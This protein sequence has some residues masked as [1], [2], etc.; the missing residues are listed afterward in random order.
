MQ[1][2][3]RQRYDP[4][5]VELVSV[6]I[7]TWQS[8]RW[9]GEAVESALDQTHS[10]LEVLVVDDG[11]TDDT[12]DVLRAFGDRIRWESIPHAGAG[13]ARNRLL[14][15]ARG[16]WV[17]FL[18]ADDLLLPEKI[19]RQIAA[20]RRAPETVDLVSAP[21]LNQKGNVQRVPSGSD[22]WLCLLEGR[23]GTTSSHLFRRQR[24]REVGG[25]DVERRA[26]QE[27]ELLVRLLAAGIR[28]A[29]I[30][31]ALC[32][33]RRVNPDSVWRSIWRDDPAGACRADASAMSSAVRH[34]RASD[35]LTPMREA[36]AGARFL[37]MA[38][39]AWR[40]GARE[41]LQVL[42]DAEE[43]GL[44]PA[45]LVSRSSA[46]YGL[47]YRIGG[48]EAAERVR[49][50]ADRTT[51]RTRRWLRGRRKDPRTREALRRPPVP[52]GDDRQAARG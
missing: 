38:R 13:T 39:S 16:T 48:F 4:G 15:L 22:A 11:S 47:L 18:D 34:L 33:K 43:L 49:W 31:E 46:A 27:Q 21:F 32:I 44:P 51:A 19:E 2:S 40:R 8:A 35:A 3:G 30:E 52:E 9:V 10:A 5:I 24:L 36:A 6:L 37:L 20:A 1:A 7:P 26:A 17:Q 23:L 25:W 45:A 50:A 14:E 12:A 41:W 42:A 29:F 28:V